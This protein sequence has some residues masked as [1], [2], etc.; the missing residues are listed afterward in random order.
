M[1]KLK[2]G[3]R[4]YGDLTVDSRIDLKDFS[5][6]PSTPAADTLTLFSIDS[7]GRSLPSFIGPSGLDS[8]LQPAI[9]RNK[10][11]LW[12]WPGN[13][14]TTTSISW[15][16][17]PPTTA[18][19][20]ATRNVATT[21]L[22]TTMKRVGY[23]TGTTTGT[24]AGVRLAAAQ[25]WRGNA[26]GLGG[27]YFVSRFGYSNTA[28]V[29]AV[30]SFVGLSAVT[31]TPSNAEPNSSTYNNSVGIGMIST[32]NNMQIITRSATAATTID[33]GTSFPANTVN[34]DMYELILFAP[35]NASSIGYKVTRLNTGDTTSGTLT[36]N[37]PVDTTL[38]GIQQW[39][40]NNSSGQSYGIDVVS[41][42]IETDY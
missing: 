24:S 42:Y 37:L 17:A 25:F 22:F 6:P 29:T 38:M 32:S 30:R 41:T 23:T 31:G 7:A 1:A 2:N 12:I 15:G 10:S 39:I 3:T 36:T 4:V 40:N 35:P 16:I 13:T 19:T 33:L 28:P 18:G 5:A 34:T 8:P 11:C 21:N 20:A 26:T 9:A 14:T 27:F